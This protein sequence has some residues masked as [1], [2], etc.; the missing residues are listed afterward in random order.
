MIEQFDLKKQGKEK[1]KKDPV[2]FKVA[3]DHVESVF[4]ESFAKLSAEMTG[5]TNPNAKAQISETANQSN[6]SDT[7]PSTAQEAKKKA[8]LQFIKTAKELIYGL[9]SN[10]I[11]RQFQTLSHS[12]SVIVNPNFQLGELISA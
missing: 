3:L 1:H 6:S 5:D 10:V 9:S 11:E 4:N 12:A 7:K 2:A 8:E